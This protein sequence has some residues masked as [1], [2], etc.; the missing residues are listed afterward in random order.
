MSVTILTIVTA[1]VVLSPPAHSPN[2]LCS[3]HCNSGT[4]TI[5]FPLTVH[6]QP[7]VLRSRSVLWGEADGILNDM[8]SLTGHEYEKTF[9]FMVLIFQ[10]YESQ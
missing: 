7:N 6:M 5:F 10:G 2:Y 8:F 4:Q 1:E 3:E 9:Y